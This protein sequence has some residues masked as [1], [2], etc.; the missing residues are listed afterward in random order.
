MSGRCGE[1]ENERLNALEHRLRLGAPVAQWVKRWPTDLAVP[2]SIPTR[3]EKKTKEKKKNLLNRKR[4]SIAHSLSLS[5]S[6][7]PDMTEI[8]LKRSSIYPSFTADKVSA[9]SGNGARDR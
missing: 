3:G 4:G 8:L 9:W 5:T 7:R 1:G 6:H 2:S